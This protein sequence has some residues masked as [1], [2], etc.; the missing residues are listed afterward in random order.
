MIIRV[1]FGG[2]LG[3]A[4]AACDSS[5][6]SIHEGAE[7]RFAVTAV[8][9]AHAGDEHSKHSSS[10]ITFRT[11]DGVRIDL[12]LG[13]VNLVPVEVKACTSV[14]SMLKGLGQRLVS[15]AWA[16]AGSHDEAEPTDVLDAL[17]GHEKYIG[18]LPLEVGDYCGVVL[19]LEPVLAS[20]SKHA[21]SGLEL[22]GHAV[23]VYP[24]YFHNTAQLSDEEYA[25]GGYD[26]AHS[27]VQFQAGHASST[28][29]LDF[30]EPVSISA[31]RHHLNIELAAHFET[32]FDG[33][34]MDDVPTVEAEQAK[35]LANIRNSIHIDTLTL[36]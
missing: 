8:G 14:A 2:L 10:Y 36:E 26:T 12:Q 33:V 22:S 34:V 6:G 9:A 21:D 23:N 28:L 4:L 1:L 25:A 29:E 19:A 17:S 7:A 20:A 31:E 27:C 5:S 18:A 24:C 30:A 11:L 13:L 15:S 3:L 16:H 32:W 35:M